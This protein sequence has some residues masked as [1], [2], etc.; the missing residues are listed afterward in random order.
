MEGWMDKKRK[1][2]V[3]VGAVFL[4]VTGIATVACSP[5]SSADNSDSATVA[6]PEVIIPE[7]NENGVITAEQWRDIH[8]D[9]YDS[10]QM[11]SENTERVS[12]IEEDP[13]IVTLYDGTGFAKDYGSA[14][15]HPYTLADVA[16]TARPHKLANCLTCKSP[17]LT[18]L[19]NAEGDD[20]YAT[21]FEE[22]YA[23]LSEPISC[24]NCHENTNG[25]LVVTAQFLTSAIGADAATIPLDDQVC[26]QCHN[27]YYFDPETKVTTLPYQNLAT[28]NPEA[29]LAYYNEIG[30]SDMTNSFSG[31]AMVKVQHPE[32]ETVLGEGNKMMGMGGFTCSSCHMSEAT[33]AEGETYTSHTLVSPLQNQALLDSSCSTCHT[34]LAAE[35]AA[36]Q[37]EVTARETTIGL[38]LEDLTLRVGAALADGSKSEAE[39]AELQSILR[40][41]QFYWDFCYV[42]NAEGA[43]NSTLARW[44]LDT[45]EAEVDRGLAMF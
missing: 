36:I 13:F 38:K 23:R 15:G 10:F 2:A 16:A 7:P 22:I 6:A 19:V 45:A 21:D 35:V 28:M 17:E 32:F 26:G 8:P 4:L 40:T 33:N 30:F 1:L 42:E 5:Q 29:I 43:H 44:L 27:E 39:I 37:S 9:I 3:C 20:I 18:A 24:Y 41:A 14:I 25:E 12:Y 11:N 31:A 34:D